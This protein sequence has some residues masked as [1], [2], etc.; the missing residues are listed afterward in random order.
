MVLVPVSKA[1]QMFENSKNSYS[2]GNMMLVLF[3]DNNYLMI[4]EFVFMMEKKE[5]KRYFK[6]W[7]YC[8]AYQDQLH[9]EASRYFD[10]RKRL[11]KHYA[12]RY[13]RNSLY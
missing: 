2:I 9:E 7:V 5:N 3:L 4:G 12:E 1:L 11:S 8:D 6:A 13:S 10:E